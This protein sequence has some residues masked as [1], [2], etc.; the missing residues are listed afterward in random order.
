MS[1][2]L[3]IIVMLLLGLI[4]IL[5]IFR[6][7]SSFLNAGFGVNSHIGDLKGSFNLE[8]FED[9]NCDEYNNKINKCENSGC[10][11]DF[12]TKKCNKRYELLDN[13]NKNK[14]EVHDYCN[15]KYIDKN[16]D[17]N[18]KNCNSDPKCEYDN[19]CVEKQCSNIL[20]QKDCNDNK[21]LGYCMWVPRV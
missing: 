5:S 21:T 9:P 3:F 12:S 17:L 2:P 1:N 6:T 20:K 18:K 10:K 8:A 16:I 14:N 4:I 7:S 15:K 11:Y 19:Q 13:S